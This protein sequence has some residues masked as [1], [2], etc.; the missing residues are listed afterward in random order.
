MAKNQHSE[1]MDSKTKSNGKTD[2]K[3]SANQNGTTSSTTTTTTTNLPGLDN[4]QVV[5]SK[6]YL[7]KEN[8]SKKK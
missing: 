2:D 7:I 5:V 4:V 1:D 8:S 6:P 3:D